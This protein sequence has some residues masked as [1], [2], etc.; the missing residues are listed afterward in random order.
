MFKTFD[1]TQLNSALNDFK[2]AKDKGNF[3]NFK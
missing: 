2:Q 1:Q 3:A